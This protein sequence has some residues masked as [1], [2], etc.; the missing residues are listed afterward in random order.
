MEVMA[1]MEYNRSIVWPYCLSV[2]ENDMTV[3]FELDITVTVPFD[4]VQL[5][6]A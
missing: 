2:T 6:V 4:C 1:Q 3:L 5:Y